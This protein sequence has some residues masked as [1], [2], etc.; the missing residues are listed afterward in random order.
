VPADIRA[1]LAVLL[2]DLAAES[3]RRAR[4]SWD[5]RKAFVAAYW[6]RLPSMPDISPASL[7][8]PGGELLR[9][10]PFASSSA[11]SRACRGE[12]GGSFQPLLRASGPIGS[13]RQHVPQ[14]LLPIAETPSDGSAITVRIGYP[15][16]GSQT[17]SLSTSRLAAD[18]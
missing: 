2:L 15:A 5:S 6:A 7:A 17:Q 8:G 16:N 11:A 1:L 14:T 3:R 13:G 12:L 4:S 9:A 18:R 10:S